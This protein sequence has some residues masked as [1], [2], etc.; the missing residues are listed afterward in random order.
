MSGLTGPTVTLQTPWLS[1][2][3]GAGAFRNC[4]LKLTC[5]ADGAIYRNVIMWPGF[6]W[7][8]VMYGGRDWLYAKCRQRDMVKEK[9]N[10]RN[11]INL[12]NWKN[13]LKQRWPV[14]FPVVQMSKFIAQMFTVLK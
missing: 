1:L 14:S 9:S 3:M 7:G 4:A 6:I 8:E 12:F 10:R 13:R 11:M 5:F 2:L